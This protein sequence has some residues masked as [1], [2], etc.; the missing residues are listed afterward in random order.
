MVT[1]EE[2]RETLDELISLQAEIRDMTNR[3]IDIKAR[4]EHLK[5][6]TNE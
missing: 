3:M 5:E 2:C 1:E 6:I 4:I